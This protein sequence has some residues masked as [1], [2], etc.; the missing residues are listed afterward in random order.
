M[1]NGAG[2]KLGNVDVLLCLNQ[3]ALQELQA[4]CV[5]WP[6]S[7]CFLMARNFGSQGEFEISVDRVT[8]SAMS[9][10]RCQTTPIYRDKTGN[11]YVLF[12]ELDDE[13]RIKE[14]LE[15]LGTIDPQK[16]AVMLCAQL[17]IKGKSVYV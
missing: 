6:D 2:N 7:V 17:G 5:E 14:G 8:L 15:F 4:D 13:T 10:I 1:S 9:K 11:I 16:Y 3:K 12:Q